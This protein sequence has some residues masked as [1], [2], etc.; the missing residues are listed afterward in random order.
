MEP[1]LLEYDVVRKLMSDFFKEKKS[2]KYPQ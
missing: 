1:D 2:L